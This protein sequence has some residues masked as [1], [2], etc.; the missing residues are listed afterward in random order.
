MVLNV[1]F[2]LRFCK[3]KLLKP[4]E[5]SIPNQS[6]KN[7]IMTDLEDELK[8]REKEKQFINN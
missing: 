8:R 2:I 3:K 5:N 7:A 4:K 6:E 1:L